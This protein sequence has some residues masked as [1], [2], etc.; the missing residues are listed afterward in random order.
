MSPEMVSQL[1]ELL[2]CPERTAQGFCNTISKS[3][4]EEVTG[5]KMIDDPY[6]RVVEI[7]GASG[8]KYY[9]VIEKGWFLSR[10]TADSIDGETVYIAI[11]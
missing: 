9:A 10:I 11:Q 7:T 3:L 8:C 2:G 1:A 5:F 4:N 6:S